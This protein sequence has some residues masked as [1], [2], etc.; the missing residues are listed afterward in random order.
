M[1][2]QNFTSVVLYNGLSSGADEIEYSF[3]SPW[4]PPADP[5]HLESYLLIM[6]DYRSP[7]AFEIISYR[8]ITGDDQIGYKLIGVSRGLFGTT[9]RTWDS[10]AIATHDLFEDYIAALGIE[11]SSNG[12]G[13]FFT[14]GR[15]SAKKVDWKDVLFKNPQIGYD[16]YDEVSEPSTPP[17]DL[18]ELYL[19]SSD[20]S[21][22]AKFDDGTVHILGVYEPPEWHD[23]DK[24][25]ASIFGSSATVNKPDNVSEGD[26]ILIFLGILGSTGAPVSA[27]SGFTLINQSGSTASGKA[28]VFAWYKVA[29]SSEPG[30]Y[31]IG[32]GGT[33]TLASWLSGRVT[34][35]SSTTPINGSD[36]NDSGGSS[37]TSLSIPGVDYNKSLLFTMITSD[38]TISSGNITYPSGTTAISG[39]M[40]NQTLG[41]AIQDLEGI[42]TSSSKDWSWTSPSCESFGINFTVNNGKF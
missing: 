21:F 1:I 15:Y 28:K 13:L 8:S 9:D 18:V 32:F 36:I 39:T 19:D 29:T 31:S 17:T 3:E 12:Y 14:D 2:I 34:G 7:T 33:T 4:N 37:T 38:N 16:Y 5:G 6:D 22:K 41:V 30:T 27:P 26:L 20:R 10:G 24:K 40:T 11:S 35:H 42:G 23:S 25:S